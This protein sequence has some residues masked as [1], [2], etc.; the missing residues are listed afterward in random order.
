M[1]AGF[2]TGVRKGLVGAVTNPA[3]GTLD[4]FSSAFEGID[5]AKNSLLGRARPQQAERKRLPRAIGGDHKLLPFRRPPGNSE[6]Q[7]RARS[8][9]VAGSWS[10]CQM[11]RNLADNSVI[12]LATSKL[13]TFLFAEMQRVGQEPRFL[14][15]VRRM[16]W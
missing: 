4:A 11:C 16:V 7:V 6:N 14:S 12:F 13:P 9:P 10:C 2:F 8:S 15:D 5:A 1:P 3:S